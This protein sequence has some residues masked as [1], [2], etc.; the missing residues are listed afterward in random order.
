[1]WARRCA[2]TAVRDRRRHPGQT[3]YGGGHR[4]EQSPAL[5]PGPLPHR[6]PASSSLQ[7]VLCA[8]VVGTA[9]LRLRPRRPQSADTETTPTEKFVASSRGRRPRCF[10]L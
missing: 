1:G 3:T 10:S 8:A 7:P 5:P 9:S 4:H 6:P 2:V